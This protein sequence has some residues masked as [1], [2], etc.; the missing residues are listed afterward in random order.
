[1]LFP[2]GLCPVS[3]AISNV[4]RSLPLRI[5]YLCHNCGACH[6]VLPGFGLHPCIPAVCPTRNSAYP[7]S[8]SSL[9]AR[10]VHN[11]RPVTHM[12]MHR[13]LPMLEYTSTVTATALKPSP[14]FRAQSQLLCA[15]GCPPKASPLQPI[16]Q[17]VHTP[18]KQNH[19]FTH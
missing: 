13:R 19:Q 1:M 6:S 8:D 4:H 14:K 11:I 15:Y 17:Q 18:A 12:Y 16:Q 5:N 7:S 2:V 10:S 9:T 3:F